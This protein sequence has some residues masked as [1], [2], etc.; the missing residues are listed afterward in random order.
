MKTILLACS[1][2]AL[3]LSVPAAPPRSVVIDS[4]VTIPA[5]SP[6][7]Y[8]LPPLRQGDV[9]TL[10]YVDGL[11]KGSGH[12]PT[13]NPDKPNLEHGDQSRLVIARGATKGK[14]GVVLAMVPPETTVKPFTYIV[15][16]TRADV[17]LR[18]HKNSDNERNP[19]S[20]TYYVTITR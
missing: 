18:I 2:L 3:N 19:G 15:Q 17:I 6:D 8:R 16:T 10:Q 14:P 4:R 7:G 9:I 1:L 12:I 20:V 5:N 11:W 13:E